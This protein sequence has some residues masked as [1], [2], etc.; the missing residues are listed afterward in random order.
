MRDCRCDGEFKRPG[1]GGICGQLLFR[2][3]GGTGE[4]EIKC[5]RCKRIQTIRL[6][7]LVAT[8]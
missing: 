1:L 5:P 4:V 3:R 2:Y 7:V 8:T 6:G